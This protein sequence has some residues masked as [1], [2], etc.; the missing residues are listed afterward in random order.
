MYTYMYKCMYIIFYSSLIQHILTIAST[1]SSPSQKTPIL[2]SQNGILL[3]Y[4]GQ[5]MLG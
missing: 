3:E 2:S 1:A 5:Q 4:K